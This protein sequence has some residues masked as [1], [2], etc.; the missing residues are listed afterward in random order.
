MFCFRL[1]VYNFLE[2][3]DNDGEFIY[4]NMRD[5]E[6]SLKRP[7]SSGHLGPYTEIGETV[8]Y[9]VETKEPAASVDWVFRGILN[10]L[11]DY[12]THPSHECFTDYRRL[13]YYK[14]FGAFDYNAPNRNYNHVVNEYIGKALG[15]SLEWDD[16]LNHLQVIAIK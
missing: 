6:P 3:R 1:F 9:K 2:S 8:Y 4:I 14:L 5:H 16:A 13:K 11:T 7:I 12:A 15:F 10:H